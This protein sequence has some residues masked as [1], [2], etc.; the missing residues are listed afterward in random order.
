MSRLKLFSIKGNPEDLCDN[1]S[2]L[3][4]QKI[5]RMM[6]AMRLF[7]AASQTWNTPVRCGSLIQPQPGLQ[8]EPQ[9]PAQPKP[10]CRQITAEMVIKGIELF[11][12][13]LICFLLPSS[14][15]CVCFHG[16]FLQCETHPGFNGSGMMW[17]F[18]W[19]EQGCRALKDASALYQRFLSS[20]KCFFFPF[21]FCKG[22][23]F[24]CAVY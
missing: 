7:P 11:L 9:G 16:G 1:K 17:F 8:Y 15:W 4:K 24:P 13:H 2:T 20:T 10:G 5:D 6:G 18:R 12:S 3:H 14:F 22:V 21:L 19:T 23:F